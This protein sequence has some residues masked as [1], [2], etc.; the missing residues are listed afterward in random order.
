MIKN[1]NKI[2]MTGT[3]IEMVKSFCRKETL[4]FEFALE[5]MQD[6]VCL[7]NMSDA[8]VSIKKQKNGRFITHGEICI[9]NVTLSEAL[10]QATKNLR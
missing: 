10:K 6:L 3:Q 5:G 7:K 4:R 9:A 1:P 8:Y 2:K